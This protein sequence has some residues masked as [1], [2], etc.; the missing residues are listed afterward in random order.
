MNA[1]A[2][3]SSGVSED[4]VLPLSVDRSETLKVKRRFLNI[5]RTRLQRIYATMSPHQ[6]CFFDLLALLFHTNHALMPGYV[7]GDCPSGMSDYAP[8]KRVLA[9]AKKHARSFSMRKGVVR[10]VDIYA[11][12]LMGS[13]GTIA[14]SGDSDFDIWLCHRRDLSQSGVEKLRCKCDS[15]E[16]WAEG[17]GLEVHFF[18]MCDEFFRRGEIAALS[19]ESSGTAQRYLLLDEFYRTGVLIEGRAPVWWLVPPDIEGDYV[20]FIETMT[21]HRF[22]RAEDYLDFGPVEDINPAE[23]FGATLWQLSKAIDAP[24]KSLLKILLLEAYACDYPRLDFLSSRYKSAVYAGEL[25]LEHLDPYV[26]LYQ[27]IE[28]HLQ[29]QRDLTRLELA[30]RCL[31]FKVNK[32]WRQICKSDDWASETVGALVKQWG[33]TE[34]DLRSMDARHEWKVDRALQE[35]KGLVSAL[36]HSYKA[37]S[38]F[39]RENA[40]VAALS[41]SDMTILGRKLFTA[42]EHKSGK[43]DIVNKG[44]CKDL[45]ESHLYLKYVEPQDASSYWLL[46][47]EP[48][49]SEQHHSRPVLRRTRS[50]TESVVWSHFNGLLTAN[51]R[52][53]IESEKT[54]IAGRDIDVLS[55]HLRKH[56]P[57]TLAKKGGVDA[58]SSNPRLIAAGT[59][60]NFSP[61][62]GRHQQLMTSARSDA[63]SY[64]GWHENL[65]HDVDYLIVTSWGE[66]LT[67]QYQGIKGLIAC[68][69]EHLRWLARSGRAC[70]L[71]PSH[72]CETRYGDTIV[73]RITELFDAVIKWFFDSCN[74]DR[75]RYV[76]RAGDSYYMLLRTCERIS[77]EFSGSFESLLGYLGQAS[78]TFTQTCFDEHALDDPILS[79]I[80]AVNKEGVVQFFYQVRK[81]QATIWVLDEH[82]ALFVDEVSFFSENALLGHFE[83][84]FESVEFRQRSS[85]Q[86]EQVPSVANNQKATRRVLPPLHFYQ[87]TSE[88]R[89][90]RLTP[91]SSNRKR[92]GGAFFDVKV[93][94]ELVN[95][96]TEFI[97]YV[98]G[99][100]FS[101]REHGKQLFEKVTEHV[102]VRRSS[103]QPYPLY[104]TDIDLSWLV[105]VQETDTPFCT[106]DYL[107]YKKR[108]EHKLNSALTKRARIFAA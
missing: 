101:V 65:V 104:I 12:Y 11:L 29:R 79:H 20:D 90:Y 94:G 64:S 34:A 49:S 82:G 26:L 91:R 45:S 2:H 67:Y 27:K 89:S 28:D 14:Q 16:V 100:E 96:K 73:R 36:T 77:R 7:D 51:T 107:R 43:I 84:F 85:P 40:A 47:R 60:I 53:I 83:Q 75:S 17:L 35:R 66:I 70:S 76:L 3:F 61:Q 48:K 63:L 71:S 30:R 57:D 5:N 6:R 50:L 88:K 97:V 33:W 22:I 81:D 38:H 32:S 54:E 98:D 9:Q 72:C 93:V 99:E 39:A 52:T 41:Q 31:Y 42:F 19:S 24:Y 46:Y 59:F 78:A 106:I 108:I 68:L 103:G 62:P 4:T 56:F 37:L 95:A 44:I 74:R 13:S 55:A 102:L 58:L 15:I 21:S 86:K 25:S 80:F 10:Q 8:S 69:C 18:L 92:P 87:I 23:Y 105:S 1:S